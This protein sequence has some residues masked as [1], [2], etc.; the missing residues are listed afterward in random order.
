MAKQTLFK[1][2]HGDLEFNDDGETK[3]YTYKGN[4]FDELTDD[5]KAEIRDDPTMQEF[6]KQFQ[7]V[8]EVLAKVFEEIKKIVLPIFNQLS[9]TIKAAE[10][11][12]EKAKT[13]EKK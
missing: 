13:D 1:L 7:L 6:I 10:A 8:A 12:A 9:E 11:E 5:E 4:P 3:V 2:E